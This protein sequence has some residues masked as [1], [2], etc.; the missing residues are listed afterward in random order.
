MISLPKAS[1]I[2]LLLL[3]FSIFFY[4]LVWVIF[5]LFF[6]VGYWQFLF[7][8]YIVLLSK[9]FIMFFPG[10]HD[11]LFY[12]PLGSFLLWNF[13]NIFFTVSLICSYSSSGSLVHELSMLNLF[14]SLILHSGC[15]SSRTPC[16][17]TFRLFNFLHLTHIYDTSNSWPVL[18]FTDCTAPSTTPYYIVNFYFSGVQV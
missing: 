17:G 16:A 8:H 11:N 14:L 6:V 10:Y 3:F 15:I 7:S 13:E 12:N 1:L 9:A 2:F 18:Q 4:I 5:S